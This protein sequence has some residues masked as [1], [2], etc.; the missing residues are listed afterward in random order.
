[1]QP[2]QKRSPHRAAS[3]RRETNATTRPSS[4]MNGAAMS[5]DMP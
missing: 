2:V 1:M 5:M 4:M 3:S